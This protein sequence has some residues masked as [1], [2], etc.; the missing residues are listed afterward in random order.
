MFTLE[1]RAE[2]FD[3]LEKKGKEVL[4]KE[5][6]YRGRISKKIGMIEEEKKKAME[7]G[8]YP[9]IF[10]RYYP[11]IDGMKVTMFT[12]IIQVR[13]DIAYYLNFHYIENDNPEIAWM[14][15]DMD[16]GK[17]YYTY[18]FLFTEHYLARFE[19]RNPGYKRYTGNI[20]E[21][22]VLDILS[23]AS[24]YKTGLDSTLIGQFLDPTEFMK[25]EQPERMR[26]IEN[27]KEVAGVD[28]K[29]LGTYFNRN[30][31]I[32][33]TKTTDG[34]GLYKMDGRKVIMITW[35]SE[36]MLTDKQKELFRT[37]TQEI[38]KLRY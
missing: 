29:L 35:L 36:E 33:I 28:D 9:H 1:D 22:V 17:S 34:Y 37:L 30:E 19:E 20:K 25:L 32:C 16:V 10:D 21:A 26:W 31:D 12:S 6:Y 4:E 5:E 38:L 24:L 8:I 23:G 13:G 15:I 2:F 11:K 18:Y 27:L 3:W 14:V 7:L